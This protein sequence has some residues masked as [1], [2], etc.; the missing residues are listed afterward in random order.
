MY[1]KV[2]VKIPTTQADIKL[3]QYQK[4]IKD[5]EESEDLNLIKR[6]KVECF[7]NLPENVVL[8]LK[9]K[10]VDEIVSTI[11]KALD[12]KHELQLKIRVDGVEYGFIPNLSDSISFGEEI[13]LEEYMK[14]VQTYDKAMAVM[15]RP[16]TYKKSDTYLIKEYTA[17]EPALDLPL[18]IVTG[19]VFF[20]RNLLLTLEIAIKNFIKAQ[21]KTDKRLSTL[22]V[23]G[24]GILQYM[25]SLEGMSL[26]ST[27]L[28]NYR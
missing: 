15:Y 14:D 25:R 16:I 7:C 28:Q 20:F 8:Q 6:K 2:K 11:D 18:N 24:V 17:Q 9:A 5:T 3:S 10:E 23:N 19:A 12:E 4:F 26:S 22:E 21:A 1:M 27:M 13:D